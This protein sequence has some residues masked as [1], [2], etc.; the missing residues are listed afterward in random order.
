MCAVR[1]T[2]MEVQKTPEEVHGWGQM[3]QGTVKKNIFKGWAT[4]L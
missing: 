2:A 3:C 1:S 4:F